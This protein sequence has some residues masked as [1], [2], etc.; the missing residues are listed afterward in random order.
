MVAKDDGSLWRSSNLGKERV[1]YDRVRIRSESSY[2]TIRTMDI[3]ASD[4]R[5]V[6]VSESSRRYYN[7]GKSRYID[8]GDDMGRIHRI[9]FDVDPY[10]IH[11]RAGKSSCIP[12][13]S[14]ALGNNSD[15][16]KSSVGAVDDTKNVS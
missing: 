3:V 13:R 12:G 5:N 16:R 1:R 8:L 2:D 10:S 4:H 15:T 11:V 7:S 9:R 6:S 14:N